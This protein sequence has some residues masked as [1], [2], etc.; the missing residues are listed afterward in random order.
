MVFD[1]IGRLVVDCDHHG[2]APRERAA[3]NGAIVAAGPEMLVQLKGMLGLAEFLINAVD[4]DTDQT[5]VVLCVNGEP[6][7][8]APISVLL[9]HT[10]AAIAKAEGR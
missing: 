9:K 6:A 5:K 4:L 3:A 7:A 10:R 1:A 8:E 2:M